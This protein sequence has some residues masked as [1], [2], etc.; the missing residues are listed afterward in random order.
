MEEKIEEKEMTWTRELA[1]RL[2]SFVDNKDYEVW[3]NG[4]KV[5]SIILKPSYSE[6][7]GVGW[8]ELSSGMPQNLDWYTTDKFT[9]SGPIREWWK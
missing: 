5:E 3:I 6:Q 9:V 7:P 2:K 1:E 4:A 8:F